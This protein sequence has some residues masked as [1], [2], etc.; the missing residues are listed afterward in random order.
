MLCQQT[1][2]G[3]REVLLHYK[4]YHNLNKHT[5][6]HPSEGEID[7]LNPVA[8]LVKGGDRIYLDNYFI[9]FIHL[10]LIRTSKRN[11]AFVFLNKSEKNAI[12]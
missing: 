6:S 5:H 9:K 11:L 1:V 2:D 12:V 4:N 7:V 8:Y 3:N 10:L